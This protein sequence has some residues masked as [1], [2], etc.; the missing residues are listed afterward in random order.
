MDGEVCIKVIIK[1]PENKKRPLKRVVNFLKDS[2]K[3][4]CLRNE[5]L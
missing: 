4:R 5:H 1:Y 3:I 2:F